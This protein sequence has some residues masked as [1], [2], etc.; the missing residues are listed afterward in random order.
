MSLLNINKMEKL[1]YR[2]NIPT[3]TAY[4]HRVTNHSEMI[5]KII[6]TLEYE[7]YRIQSL[8]GLNDPWWHD[9]NPDLMS[10]MLIPGWKLGESQHFSPDLYLTITHHLEN[11]IIIYVTQ[12]IKQ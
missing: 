6:K 10:M 7:R 5:K 8:N 11:E 4:I 2:K 12:Q 1:S 9:S 3:V